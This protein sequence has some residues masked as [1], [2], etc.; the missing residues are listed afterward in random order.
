[1]PL[2]GIRDRALKLP[3][4]REP[5]LPSKVLLSEQISSFATY[6]PQLAKRQAIELGKFFKIC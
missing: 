2:S 6:L 1:M 5:P 3:V 4:P